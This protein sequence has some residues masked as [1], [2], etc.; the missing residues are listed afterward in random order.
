M[1]P[2]KTI[3]PLARA[4]VCAIQEKNAM[5]FPAS[6]LCQEVS[7]EAPPPEAQAEVGT[8]LKL[9]VWLKDEMLRLGWSGRA[10][11]FA[12]KPEPRWIV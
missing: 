5:R 8:S 11:T 3:P 7:P 6:W 9:M 10:P 4:L 12:S 2:S 1:N